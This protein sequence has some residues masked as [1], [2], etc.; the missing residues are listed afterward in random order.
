[1]FVVEIDYVICTYYVEKL[2]VVSNVKRRL[3]DVIER[4]LE[5]V[6]IVLVFEL[7]LTLIDYGDCIDYIKD[8]ESSISLIFSSLV[9][10]FDCVYVKCDV[11]NISI[12]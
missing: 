4:K 6:D 9:S 3:D 5:R 7:G 10:E 11:L 12:T 2:E 1:M 8:K